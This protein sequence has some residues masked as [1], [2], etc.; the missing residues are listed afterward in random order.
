M[1]SFDPRSQQ[2]F[3][4]APRPGVQS[5]GWGPRVLGPM[6]PPPFQMVQMLQQLLQSL[7]QLAG[8][9]TGLAGT[10]PPGASP[11]VALPTGVSSPAGSVLG[12]VSAT[13][14]G[15]SP[16]GGYGGSS[17]ILGA[18][19]APPTPSDPQEFASYLQAQRLGGTLQGK[20]GIAQR[21]AIPGTRFGTV[22]ESQPWQASLARNYAYQFAAY[23]V[24]ADALTPQ[25]MQAGQQAM[26]GMSEDARLF[27][28]VASV[29]KGNLLGGPGFYDNP[30]L[31]NLLQYK[32]LG[33]LASK[34]GVGETDVQS[35]GAITIALNSGKL[36]LDEVI[37]SGT[38]DNLDRYGQ[39]I[40]YVKGGLFNQD[41]EYYDSRPL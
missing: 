41:L 31:K 25:G 1:L 3:G 4:F 9:W 40:N 33:D 17:G 16:T 22:A 36:T 15:G 2:V 28:Q 37:K 6:G 5:Y 18:V 35:I 19:G 14:A 26:N 20:T 7:S 32:G 38:I 8:N 30:G 10:S 34:P 29:F 13:G 24:G 21:D 39:V 12:G 27:M 11:L 23:A